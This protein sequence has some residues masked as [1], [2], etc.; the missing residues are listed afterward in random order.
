MN[1]KNSQS[2]VIDKKS[3]SLFHEKYKILYENRATLNLSRRLK[4][5]EEELPIKKK[6]PVRIIEK[7]L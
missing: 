3:V 5:Q 4:Y 6:K 1:D 7:S 2:F